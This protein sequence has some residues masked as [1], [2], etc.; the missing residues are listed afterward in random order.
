MNLIPVLRIILLIAIGSISSLA[1]NVEAEIARQ[2][3]E[4]Q[5]LDAAVRQL[6]GQAEA[7]QREIGR[8]LCTTGL[9]SAT[10]VD[11]FLVRSDSD[12]TV[13]LAMISVVNEAPSCLPLALDLIATFVDGQGNLVCGGSVREVARP[14]EASGVITLTI[15]PLNLQQFVRWRN[16]PPRTNSRFQILYCLTPDG[17]TEI[18]ASNLAAARSIRLR[19][20]A[21]AGIGGVGTREF[22]I[23]IQ[24]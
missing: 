24:R 15:Q 16:E 10:G 6:E 20:V 12:S 4:I 18:A 17:L 1:Q 13:E 23:S 9:D 11:E 7:L 21:R 19:A 2:R 5:R 14:A 22:V 3:A 8:P